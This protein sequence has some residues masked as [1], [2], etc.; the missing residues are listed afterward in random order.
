MRNKT[1]IGLMT[2]L[3]GLLAGE[4][5]A[6]NLTNYTAGDV[7]LCFRN[8]GTHDLVVDA[9]PI[10]TFTSLTM[11]QRYSITAY[12]GSQLGQ[13]STNSLDWS[14]FTWL[15]NNTL[16][17][18]RPRSSLNVQTFP[19]LDANS[20][21]QHSTGLRMASIVAGAG[22]A[23]IY[24]PEIAYSTGTG[25]VE[26]DISAGN[27]DYPNGQSYK[28]ALFGSYNGN[29]NGTFQGNPE[30]TTTNHFTTQGKVVRSDFY[31]LTPTGGY[32]LAQFLGYFELNTNGLMA[33]VANPTPPTVT[34][35][36]ASAIVDTNAQLN[37]TINPN[38]DATT[39]YF[40]YGLDTTYG[41]TTATTNVGTTSGTYSLSVS[42]LS[43]G[44]TYH[45]QAVAYNFNGG[46]N[47]GG[48]LTFT[49]TGGGTPSTPVF[50]G[51]KFSGGVATINYTTGLHGTYT[52]RYATNLTTAG[53]PATWPALLTLSSGDNAVH[54]ATN[55]TS[56]PIRFYTITAQ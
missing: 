35:L 38:S 34:T 39:L 37:A 52:L 3:A 31:Q 43:A 18:T 24:S 6:G 50:A 14:A 45:F 49:T 28:E 11:N 1:K 40:Q 9:G 44:T 13:L 23:A 21:A 15:A 47:Y 53:N 48:D 56:D 8:G 16:Y 10:S 20:A 51:I 26:E 46:T 27:P 17:M 54:T 32:G 7:L 5:V 19:W 42:N 41:S 22:D 33:Y 55:T 36:A 30:N 25:I 4:A 12:T 29:F 2:L